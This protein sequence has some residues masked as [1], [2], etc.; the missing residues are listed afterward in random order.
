MAWFMLH[1]LCI[2]LDDPCEPRWIWQ[3]QHLSFNDTEIEC[4]F[5]IGFIHLTVREQIV[6]LCFLK[7]HEALEIISLF[8]TQ[9]GHD[10]KVTGV[11]GNFRTI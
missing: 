9:V 7:I 5:Q 1:N 6:V 4:K 10:P 3:V 8:V 2:K 11:R